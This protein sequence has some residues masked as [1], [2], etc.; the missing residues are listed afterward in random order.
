VDD[1][2]EAG[3]ID[4]LIVEFPDQEIT[5]EAFGELLSL[6]DRGIIRILDLVFLRKDTEG[7]AQMLTVAELAAEGNVDLAPFEGASSG[8]L[9]MEDVMAAAAAIEPGR[10]A[11]VL[12]YENVWA[13][14]FAAA[15][16]S[17]GAQ[18]VAS[19]RIPIPA[20]IAALDEAERETAHAGQGA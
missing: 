2:V 16:I 18:L 17:K 12:L 19:G 6:V 15:L 13:G 20:M 4:Y 7:V 9:G 8:L 1:R 14:P 3:P 11:G 10:V 5:G